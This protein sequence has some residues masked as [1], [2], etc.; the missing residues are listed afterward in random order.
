MYGIP[1]CD[2]FVKPK[3]PRNSLSEL[4]PRALRMATIT[5]Q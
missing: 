5:N 2:K 4:R 3:P 1:A